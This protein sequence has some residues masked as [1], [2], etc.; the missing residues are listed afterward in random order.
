MNGSTL[1]KKWLAD[2][3]VFSTKKDIGNAFTFEIAGLPLV[4]ITK[5]DFYKFYAKPNYGV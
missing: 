1:I 4:K 2:D 3:N 5:A